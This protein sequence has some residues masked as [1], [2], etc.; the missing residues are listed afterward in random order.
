MLEAGS[1]RYSG[2]PPRPAGHY[3]QLGPLIARNREGHFGP[4]F[5][6]FF[7]LPVP[8]M[9]FLPEMACGMR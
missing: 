1:S 6:P 3:G 7:L 4:L 2:E 8:A 9:A 5:S